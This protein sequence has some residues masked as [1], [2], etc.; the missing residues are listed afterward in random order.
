M[1]K[2]A[3]VYLC[4]PKPYNKLKH[5][6]MLFHA[7]ISDEDD[8]ANSPVCQFANCQFQRLADLVQ[9]EIIPNP[10]EEHKNNLSPETTEN[11]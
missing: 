9:G 3:Q 7:D 2:S 6:E 10:A 4:Y 8:R 5:E 1:K 11:I